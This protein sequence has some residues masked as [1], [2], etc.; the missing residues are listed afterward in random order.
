MTS[1]FL[2]RGNP[3]SF[4]HSKGLLMDSQT[5][6]DKL[7]TGFVP[8]VEDDFKTPYL[9]TNDGES[10]D[11]Q[12]KLVGMSGADSIEL[13]HKAT[14]TSIDATGNIT[15]TIDDGKL[16]SLAIIKCLYGR[17]DNQPI[18]NQV[19]PQIGDP[20]DLAG[21]LGMDQKAFNL[22]GIDVL[23]FLGMRKDADTQAKN[24]SKATLNGTG[25]GG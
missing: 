8:K 14:V 17:E 15:S 23:N 2:L 6:R 4:S 25:G 3:I 16:A 20:A 21:I 11:G 5:L 22:L 18:F 7:Q 13:R 24:D 1:L 10:L 19:M 12:F 9:V